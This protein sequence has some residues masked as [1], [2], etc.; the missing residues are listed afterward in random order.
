MS[1]QTPDRTPG[2]A[3][4]EPGGPPAPTPDAP[5][6]GTPD[7]PAGTPDAPSPGRAGGGL[8]RYGHLAPWVLVPV[9]LAVGYLA[10][11]GP[12]DLRSQYQGAAVALVAAP[13]LAWLLTRS[14]R[15]AHHTAG[16]VVAAL[17]PAL[18]LISLHGTDWYFS[19]PFGDASFRL[20]YATR[21]AD[22]PS[23][24]D[25][26]FRDVPAFYSPGWF[27]VVGL[28]ARLT[29]TPAWQVYKWA[30]IATLYLAAVL[31]FALWRRTCGTRLSAAVLAVTVIGLPSADYGWLWNQTLMFSGAYEPYSWLVA[32]PAPA[33]LVWF[34]VSR[35]PFD[36]RRGVALGVALGAAA[37]LYNLFA[38]VLVVAV[39]LVV[40]VLRR[41]DRGRWTEVAVAGLTAVVLVSPWLG[42]FLVDWLA[43]GRPEA[44]ATTWLEDDA[45]YV[46]LFSPSSSVWFALALLGA[47]GLLTVDASVHRR[48]RGLQALL[49]AVLLL[50]VGQLVL[51]QAGRGVLFHRL[52][53]V[54]GITLLAAGTLTV[55]ALYPRAKA[56]SAAALARAPAPGRLRPRRVL[57]AVLTVALFLGLAGHAR[58]WTLRE[59]DLRRIALDTAYPDGSYPESTPQVVKDNEAGS[60]AVD[61]L[62]AAIRE[63]S[64]AAGQEEPGEVLTDKLALAATVPLHLYQQWWALYANPLGEY[65]A[66]RAFLE[67]LTGLDSA[68]F[69]AR[70]RGEPGA[71]TVFVLRTADDDPDSVEYTS[72]DYDVAAGGSIDWTLR[73]PVDALRGPDFVSTTVGEYVVASLRT[74]S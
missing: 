16:A 58:E 18:T 4:P 1:T 37:W 65:P 67:G 12:G 61:D 9:V 74:G 49:L 64:A 7:A 20:E 70:L 22:D 72:T 45:S 50:G 34:G 56:W 73:L 17:L 23:L 55:A 27:W 43:A 46:R 54:L 31:A 36:W 33:L 5:R 29:G 30:A 6:A 71:P 44:L 28:V 32:L 21:F 41:R 10:L 25:Y 38:L 19:G 3:D 51:G 42:P 39:L 53:L 11:P 59:T 35:G 24:A 57:A 47:V 63:T 68:E 40:V 26:T 60:A 62:V 15:L 52:L 14:S 66:R 8:V 13:L 48:M 69:A 2:S